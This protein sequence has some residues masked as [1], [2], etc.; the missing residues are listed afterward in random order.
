MN[1]IQLSTGIVAA[2]EEEGTG[3]PI[4]L[5]HGFCGSWL[6]WEKVIP[7]L[8][9]YGRVIAPDLRG[10]GESSSAGSEAEYDM[11]RL[12]DD[13]AAL[14][15]ALDI[16][17]ATIFGH[18]LGGYVALA[19][20]EKYPARLQSLGLVHSTAYGDT[21]QAKDN[22]L[23][24]VDTIR[25]QGVAAFVDGLVPKLFA[26]ANREN[27]PEWVEQAKR[28][29]YGTSA[30]GAA[31]CALGMRARP[32]RVSVLEKLEMP[33]LLLAGQSDEV[34]APEKRFPVAG[35]NVTAVTLEAVGHMSMLEDAAA[36]VD[37]LGAFL[38]GSRGGKDV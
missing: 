3:E 16:E 38:K 5:L 20:A 15:D 14:L 34:I 27:R 23:K 32:D 13:A 4:V 36:L 1:K 37:S 29:G 33:V 18:S 9:L 24:A 7:S 19:F 11:E 21:E 35:P 31:G 25:E 12:A 26:P 8:A 10:H 2:Y 28:I 22:R 6:Y 30:E 17:R